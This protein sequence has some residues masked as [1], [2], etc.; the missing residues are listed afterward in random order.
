VC[1]EH[2]IVRNIRWV[3]YCDLRIAVAPNFQC[4]LGRLTLGIIAISI[5]W[6]R[7]CDVGIAI[8]TK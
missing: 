3:W 7:F 8:S 6:V 5:R 1:E 2:Y 4:G